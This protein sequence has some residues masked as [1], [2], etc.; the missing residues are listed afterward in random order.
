MVIIFNPIKNNPKKDKLKEI[1]NTNNRWYKRKK[2]FLIAVAY[3]LIHEGV[4][5]DAYDSQN[6][7]YDFSSMFTEIEPILKKYDLKFCNQESTI[8]ESRNKRIS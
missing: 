5:K 3:F 2:L 8:G 6:K 1:E 4:Y 7:T